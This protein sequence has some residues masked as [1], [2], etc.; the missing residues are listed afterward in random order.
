MKSYFLFYFLSIYNPII[1]QK[2][3]LSVQISGFDSDRGKAMVMLLN[4]QEQEVHSAILPITDKK[5]SISF[6]DLSSGK[7]AVKAFHDANGNG[8]LDTNLWGFP[9]EKWGVSNG[10]SAKLGPPDFKK[11]LF[12]VKQDRQIIIKLG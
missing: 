3:I 10:I 2:H 7:Y 8:K 12:E 4:D 9:K 11:M 1:A 5:A 6:K